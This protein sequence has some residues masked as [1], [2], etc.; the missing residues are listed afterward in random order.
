MSCHM[1]L[2]AVISGTGLDGAVLRDDHCQPPASIL[3]SKSDDSFN[4]KV[5]RVF[6]MAGASFYI[7]LGRSI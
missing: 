7:V 1:I 4:K 3:F 5:F 2:I 6:Q